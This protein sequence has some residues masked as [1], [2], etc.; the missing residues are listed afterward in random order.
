MLPVPQEL[1]VPQ[2]LPVRRVLLAPQGPRVLQGSQS[3]PQGPRAPPGPQGQS[4]PQVQQAQPE[5]PAQ[6]V[7]QDLQVIHHPERKERRAQLAL[8]VL[9]VRQEQLAQR[10]HRQRVRQAQSGLLDPRVPRVP[11]GQLV[12]QDLQVRWELPA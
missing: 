11:Q 1:Q 10:G 2:D 5:L 3:V 12:R 9:L 7:P 4:V 8:R 6:R